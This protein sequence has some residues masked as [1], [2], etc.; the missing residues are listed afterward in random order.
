MPKFPRFAERLKFI[1]GSVFET[2]RPKMMQMGDELIKLHI[3]DTYL[4]PPYSI[5][6]DSTFIENSEGFNRYCNTFGFDLLRETLSEKVKTDNQLNAKFNN[7]MMTCGACNALNISCQS[8]IDPGEEVIVLT[9]FWPFIKG[10]INTVGGNII[11]VPFYTILFQ[12]PDLDIRDYLESFITPKTIALYLNTPNNPSGKVLNR[13]QLEQ[14]AEFAH[15]NNFWIISDEAYDGMTYDNHL[16]ISIGS[17]PG[18]FAQTLS[19]FTFSKV[20]MFSGLRLGYVVTDE[21]TLVNLNKVMVHQLYSPAT[22]SQQMMIDPVKNRDQ[23]LNSFVKHCQESRDLILDNLKIAP[24]IPEGAY[25]L[26]FSINDYLNGRDY[27]KV[28]NQCFDNGVS[29]APGNNFGENYA[30]Y[31]RLCFMGESPDRLEIAID[32]LNKIFPD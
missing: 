23:W 24:Q 28:I 18:M 14:V 26:F 17:F 20:F 15:K 2:Y 1:T 30:D 21:S 7:I 3:G 29:V 10:M 6:I 25:Y 13:G 32:R 5:P 19:I 16:H 9:P 22:I 12:Q 31:I 27:R 8:L 11:E 4:S